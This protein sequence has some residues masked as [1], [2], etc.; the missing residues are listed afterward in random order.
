[1]RSQTVSLSAQTIGL[2]LR[3]HLNPFLFDFLLD[4]IYHGNW[5]GLLFLSFLKEA[6]KKSQQSDNDKSIIVETRLSFFRFFKLPSFFL[7]FIFH[8]VGLSGGIV[9]GLLLFFFFYRLLP[10]CW[11]LK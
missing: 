6:A 1:V 8:F 7:T 9:S 2:T 3:E 10:S 11:F 4:H 5:K